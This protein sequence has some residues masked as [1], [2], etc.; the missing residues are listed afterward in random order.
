ML[1][2]VLPDVACCLVIDVGRVEKSDPGV[3]RWR[4]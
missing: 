2:L 3:E 4:E 1:L